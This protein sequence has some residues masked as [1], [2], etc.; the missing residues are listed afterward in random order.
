MA[1]ADSDNPWVDMARQAV[2]SITKA[3]E[4]M[5]QYS[6]QAVGGPQRLGAGNGAQP[7]QQLAPDATPKQIADAVYKAPGLPIG[8]KTSAWYEV[9]FELHVQVDPAVISKTMAHL[10]EHAEPTPPPFTGLFED[11]NNPPSF[12][13]A[14]FLQQ[15]PI[16]Q[17]NPQYAQAVLRAFDGAFGNE[18]EDD[19]AEPDQDAEEDQPA[20]VAAPVPPPTPEPAPQPAPQPVGRRKP[21]AQQP[22]AEPSVIDTTGSETS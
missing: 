3:A 6:R 14:Q 11:E 17:Q 18:G 8:L 22:F 7:Q 19:D 2:G 5:T 20:V 1:P 4:Q 9:F 21:K 13:L 12:Y 16:W 10:L 15:L